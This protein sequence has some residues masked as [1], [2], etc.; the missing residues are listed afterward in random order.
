VKRRN[1]LIAAL[2][3]VSFTAG[4]FAQQSS[5]APPTSSQNAPSSDISTI[6][7]CLDSERGN[8]ILI[9]N[10][11]SMVYALKGVGN[12]LDKYVHHEVEVRGQMLPGVMKT[13][14]KP[15]K[16]ADNPSDALR[17]VS[18]VTFQ[19]PDVTKDVRMVSKHCEAADSQ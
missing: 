10:R 3:L 5:T 14:V 9:E 13:G 18:G 6:R 1:T 16:S 8:Y 17:A 2:A 4:A 12:K 19:V 11:T 7:G 15:E